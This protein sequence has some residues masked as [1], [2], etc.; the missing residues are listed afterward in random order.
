MPVATRARR[1][2]LGCAPNGGDRR[3]ASTIGF[4]TLPAPS[5]VDLDLVA[6]LDDAGSGGRAGEDHVARL[7]RDEA[8]EVGDEQAEGEDEVGAGVVLA[9]S[10][11]TGGSAASP[12]RPRRRRS[13]GRSG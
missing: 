6:G 12:G 13:A 2:R 8:R 5:S 11:L 10:P 7:E 9:I 1:P 3:A 4:V